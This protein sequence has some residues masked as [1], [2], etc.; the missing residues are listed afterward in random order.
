MHVHIC[1]SISKK[2][3][4]LFFLIL[5]QFE[6]YSDEK[7]IECCYCVSEEEIL[8]FQYTS[9]LCICSRQLIGPLFS[10]AYSLPLLLISPSLYPSFIVLKNCEL[11]SL[12][13]SS[14]LFPFSDHDQS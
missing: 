3:W 1:S 2:A 11:K 9:T 13:R 10:Q 8:P 14:F 4:H 6:A 5:P 12:Q 7:E